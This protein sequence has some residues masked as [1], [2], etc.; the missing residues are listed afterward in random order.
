MITNENRSLD[1]DVLVRA[2]EWVRREISRVEQ[3]RG[4]MERAITAAREEERLLTRLLALRRGEMTV[5]DGGHSESDTVATA[6]QSSPE[7]RQEA[8]HPAVQAVVRELAAAG[9]PLHIS[10]LMRL[11][12]GQGVQ[13]PGAGRQANLITHIRR[14]VEIVRTSR[15][16]YG[17]AAWGL[18]NMP[19]TP[20]RKRRRKRVRSTAVSERAGV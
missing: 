19:T 11:L 20:Q 17:L 14:E 2:L 7:M 13:I 4:E 18:E 1:V 15:G 16:M 6:E 3:Q 8:R 12:R 5:A 10:D 9:R